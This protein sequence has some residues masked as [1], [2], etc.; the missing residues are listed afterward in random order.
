MLNNS[1]KL[2]GRLRVGLIQAGELAS[3]CL[4]WLGLQVMVIMA[5]QTH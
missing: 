3:L 4:I 1:N 2:T 5:Q